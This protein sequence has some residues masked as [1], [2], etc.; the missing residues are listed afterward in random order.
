M[1]NKNRVEKFGGVYVRLQ[2]LTFVG[3]A[4]FRHGYKNILFM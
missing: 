1:I 4:G 3:V 2:P